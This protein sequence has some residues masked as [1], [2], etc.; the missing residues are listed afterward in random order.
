MIKSIDVMKKNLLLFCTL[1]LSI[2]AMV[3]CDHVTS[4]S[5]GTMQG[6][7]TVDRNFLYPEMIDTFYKA[8]NVADF[9]LKTGDRVYLTLSYEY[10]NYYG[11]LMAKYRVKSVEAKATTGVLTAA[12][13]VDEAVYSSPIASLQPVLIDGEYST[14]MWMWKDYQNICVG[15][16]SNG[17]QG[18]FKLSPVKLSGD[19]ICYA[20]NAKIEDGNKYTKELLSFDISSLVNMLPAAD[21]EKLQQLDSVCTKITLRWYNSKKDVVEIA[22]LTAGKYKNGF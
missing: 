11:P 18:D 2:I 6:L 7:F 16:Y 9:D 3:S 13:D 14:A 20:L 17:T 8:E 15:Y 1:F 21:V 19:T 12:Q 22:N 4:G 10:D 5:K